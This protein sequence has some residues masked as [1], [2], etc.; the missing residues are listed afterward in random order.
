MDNLISFFRK[1]LPE[2]VP[3]ALME[4]PDN[5]IVL[6]IN[7]GFHEFPFFNML[8]EPQLIGVTVSDQ[9][10]DF[11]EV[12]K[13]AILDNNKIQ[14]VSFDVTFERTIIAEADK[15]A[16]FSVNEITL[17]AGF[18]KK[19]YVNRF[20]KRAIIKDNFIIK[21][22]DLKVYQKLIAFFY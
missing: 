10:F 6:K 17:R 13:M 16:V 3:L 12:T 5:I 15:V 22:F 11:Q 9:Q 8:Y 1:K 2:F 4:I 7:G 19:W 20:F 21:T 14:Q 18:L